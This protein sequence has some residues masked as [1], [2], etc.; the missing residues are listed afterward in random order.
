MKIYYG[1]FSE[2]VVAVE[3]IHKILIEFLALAVGL[4]VLFMPYWLGD[5]FII[6]TN[7]APDR[8]NAIPREPKAR[9]K[10]FVRNLLR[11]MWLYLTI[12]SALLLYDLFILLSSLF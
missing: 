11:S 4:I 12:L 9:R 5:L 7:D 2:V 10:W 8:N 3:P 1:S 6:L